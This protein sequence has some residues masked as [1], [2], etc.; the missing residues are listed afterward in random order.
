MT[1][2][3]FQTHPKTET[4][5]RLNIHLFIYKFHDLN[6]RTCAQLSYRNIQELLYMV[7]YVR[8][9]TN[10]ELDM[11]NCFD[12]QKEL[13]PVQSVHLAHNKPRSAEIILK[14]L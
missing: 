3:L 11:Y 4:S 7:M 12:V 9:C 13:L 14:Q 10:F 1:F 2:N 8:N 6:D 5:K